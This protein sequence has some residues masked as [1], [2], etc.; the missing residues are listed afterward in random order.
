MY[1]PIKI[2][3]TLR[4]PIIIQGYITFNA[5]LRILLFGRL[6]DVEKAHASIPIQCDDDLFN[7]S[8]A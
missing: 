7:V 8:A 6:Q 3:A 1:E 5:L 2:E 4:S